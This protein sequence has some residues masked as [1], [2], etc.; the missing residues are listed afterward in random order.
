[1]SEQE[2]HKLDETFRSMI[3]R[4]SF[5]PPAANLDTMRAN[6][7]Q[8]QLGRLQTENG[9]LKAAL[10]IVML[11]LGSTGYVLLKGNAPVRQESVVQQILKVKQ[12]DTVYITRTERV[13]IR[14]PIPESI[15][16]GPDLAQNNY[17]ELD[18]QSNANKNSETLP[19]EETATLHP[20]IGIHKNRSFDSKN[21][22]ENNGAANRKR[23]IFNNQPLTQN[24][25]RRKQAGKVESYGQ[26][27]TDNKALI[28][29]SI[30]S[31]DGLT[32][33]AEE[34]NEGKPD[35]LNLDF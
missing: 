14:V 32:N 26:N 10:G 8:I 17:E 23:S 7:L 16:D 30:L 20:K 11:L 6:V 5:E 4:M 24:L 27:F 18:N 29:D 25:N 3:E 15:D 22:I 35:L 33:T 34:L 19:N 31:A 2:P 9:W 21:I 13:Y 12:T 28:G 1:M